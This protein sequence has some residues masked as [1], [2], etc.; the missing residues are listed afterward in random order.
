[1]REKLL[2]IA[3]VSGYSL[4]LF[5]LWHPI[6]KVYRF[7]LDLGLSHYVLSEKFFYVKSLT[8]IPFISLVLATPNIKVLKKAG[9]IGIGVIVFLFIDFFAVKSGMENVQRNPT[10]FITYRIIKIFLPFLLWIIFCYPYLGDLFSPRMKE[11]SASYYTCPICEAEHANIINH[12]REVH[13]E[14]SFKI[15]KVKRFIAEN[16]QLSS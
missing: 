6:S 1:M 5:I 10:A 4:G 8:L 16:P 2:F 14:N 9:I 15:K 7:F 12:I 3:K 11:A 13:G